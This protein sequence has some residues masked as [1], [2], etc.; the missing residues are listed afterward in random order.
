MR[1]FLFGI[2]L[3]SLLSSCDEPLTDPNAI[4]ERSIEV[5]GGKNYENVSFEFDFRDR[6]YSLTRQGAIFTYTRV[7]ED[8]VGTI[9][10]ELINATKFQRYLNDTKVVIS[11][12]RT[13]AFTSSVNSVLYFIQLPYLLNDKAVKKE[14][15][16]EIEIEGNQYYKVKVTFEKVGGGEDFED[17]FCYWFNKETFTMDYLAYSYNEID[18]GLGTRFRKAINPRRI[19]GIL[20]QDYVNYGPLNTLGIQPAE[21]HDK[22]FVEGQLKE[23]SKIENLNIKV[24]SL[25]S[26]S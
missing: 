13:A 3:I 4:V 15:L 22:L 10:D 11:S 9:K 2:V 17:V 24:Q 18:E 16:G 8:A 12:E 5:H 19:G 21:I 14:F 6:H 7:T 26:T 1:K 25:D 23:L 20:F